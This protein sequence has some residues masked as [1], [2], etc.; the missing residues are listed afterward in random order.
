MPLSASL[1]GPCGLRGR[2]ANEIER[3]DIH[4]GQEHK[5][6]VQGPDAEAQDPPPP[7]HSL[8]VRNARGLHAD[9]PSADMC[10][11]LVS[12]PAANAATGPSTHFSWIVS[13]DSRYG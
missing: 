9:G 10:V 3:A 7:N 11:K 2:V 4:D 5:R 6:S 13:R 8:S 12:T 1:C